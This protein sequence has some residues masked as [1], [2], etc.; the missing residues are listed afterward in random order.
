MGQISV[1][2]VG[3]VLWVPCEIDPSNVGQCSLM[4]GR[5]VLCGREES[6]VEQNGLGWNRALQ[7]SL[8]NHKKV[9][10]SLGPEEVL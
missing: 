7:K 8:R 5:E 9:F 2:W 1:M 3:G 4:W 6:Y 10:S